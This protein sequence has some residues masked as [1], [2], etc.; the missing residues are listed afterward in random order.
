M[1]KKNEKPTSPFKKS[2]VYYYSRVQ[3]MPVTEN[4]KGVVMLIGCYDPLA[5]IH[6][7]PRKY[8]KHDDK[9]GEY[10]IRDE[11]IRAKFQTELMRF[12]K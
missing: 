2:E 9:T 12:V 3:A 5:L 7:I 10:Y 8:L 6:V 1:K 4:E 11:Y